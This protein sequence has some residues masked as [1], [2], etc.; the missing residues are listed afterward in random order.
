MTPARARA[1]TISPRIAPSRGKSP[2]ERRS[3]AHAACGSG[4]GGGRG[5][6]SRAGTAHGHGPIALGREACPPGRP[7]HGV[8]RHETWEGRQKTSR[9]RF[10]RVPAACRVLR[11]SPSRPRHASQ[12]DAL[13]ARA[14]TSTPPERV[15]RQFENSTAAAKMAGERRT[16]RSKHRRQHVRAKEVR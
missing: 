9:R 6:G 10:C 1:G 12:C 16:R 5:G 4:S 3:A 11:S 8:E 15:S 14:R 7:Q 13:G 2:G